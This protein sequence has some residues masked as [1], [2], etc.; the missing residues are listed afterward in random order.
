MKQL[1]VVAGETSGDMYAARV[2][3][4]IKQEVGPLRIIGMGGEELS[5][6]G[7]QQLVSTDD[8]SFGL[9]GAIFGLPS[10]LKRAHKLLNRVEKDKPE[11]ALLVDYSGFNMYLARG[12]RRRNIPVVHY[13][14]PTAWTWGKWRAKWLARQQVQVAAIF[15]REYEVYRD[16]GAD[17]EYVGHPLCD[18]IDAPFNQRRCREQLEGIINN[19]GGEELQPG[20]KVLV[21]LPGSRRSEIEEHLPP[22]LAAA[23]QLQEENYLRPIIAVKAGDSKLVKKQLG[24]SLAE[25]V[26]LIGGHTRKVLGGADL[27]LIASGSATLEAALIGC[28]QVV[29]YKTDFLTGLAAR[30]FLRT[31][32]ISLPNLIAGR[33]IVPELVQKQARDDIIYNKAQELLRDNKAV[34]AQQQGY[35]AVREK[36][37]SAGAA[38]NTARLVIKT[39]N[40]DYYPEGD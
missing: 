30:M 32:H 23:R 39:G 38:E 1:V 34:L 27:G 40:L 15:P 36:L 16:A 22:M 12:L 14:P 18:E 33:K 9:T 10:H 25:E 2:V 6:L 4:N 19:K 7:Q 8:D 13:I 31:E 28:P 5:R 35:R 20:E 3:K 26:E 24:K 21:L 17:V 37:G 29:I 11:V